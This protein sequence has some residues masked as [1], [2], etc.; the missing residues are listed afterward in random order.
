MPSLPSAALFMCRGLPFHSFPMF[1]EKGVAMSRNRFLRLLK[2]FAPA[3]DAVFT[4]ATMLH[5]RVCHFCSPVLAFPCRIRMTR[6]HMGAKCQP[7]F[8]DNSEKHAI[9]IYGNCQP[10]A[11]LPLSSR[12][13]RNPA[14]TRRWDVTGIYNADF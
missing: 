4:V 10:E 14:E 5:R 3:S 8:S 2:P 12:R 1:C 7:C 6:F 9:A 13:E 11:V